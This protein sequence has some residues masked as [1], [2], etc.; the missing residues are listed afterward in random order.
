MPDD[1][2]CPQCGTPLQP[3]ALA[4]LCPACLLRQGAA[5]DTITGAGRAFVPPSIS[6]LSAKFPQLEILSLIG[7]GGM[8]AVYKARQRGL[9]R[10]VA[11]KILPPAI[12]EDPAFAGR[13]ARE[14]KALAKLNHPGIVTIHDFGCADGL[15]FFLMEFVDGVNLR[16]LLNAG[17]V[18]PREALAI[19]PQ[20]C[21]ALQFAHDQ[22]IVHRDIK[23]ENILLDRLGRVKVA[24]FGLAKLIGNEADSLPETGG[25]STHSP[26]LTEAGKIMGTPSYMAPEQTEH[27]DEVDHRADIYALGVV[28][29]QMLTGELPGKCVEAPSKKVRIDVRLDEVVL[30]ALEKNPDLRYAQASVFKTQVETIAATPG[31]AAAHAAGIAAKATYTSY[32]GFWR[33]ALALFIDCT[34]V[35]IVVFPFLMAMD[36]IAPGSAVVSVPFHLFTTEHVIDSKQ[37]GSKNADGSTTAVDNRIVEVTVLN[38]WKY[39]YRD[40]ISHNAGDETKSRQLID[41]S[42]RQNIGATS[43]DDLEPWFLLIY[44]ILMESSIYQASIGKMMTG[45]RVVDSNG[46]RLSLVRATGRNI[47]KIVSCLTLMIGFM[48]AGWTKRKQALHDI[49]AGC[50]VTT[51]QKPETASAWRPGIERGMNSTPPEHNVTPPSRTEQTVGVVFAWAG[52]ILQLGL[53]YGVIWSG[54]GMMRT[55]ALIGASGIID[56]KTLAGAIGSVLEASCIGLVTGILGLVLLS[57]ALMAMRYRAPWFYW[58]LVINSWLLIFAFPIGTGFAIFF[59]IYCSKHRAEFFILPHKTSDLG[60]GSTPLSRLGLG[61]LLL[62]VLGTP[63]LLMFFSREPAADYIAVFALLTILLALI[64]GIISRTSRLGR[65]VIWGCIA[66]IIG[67]GVLLGFSLHQRKI[68]SKRMQE[69][70]L[71]H[72][73][74]QETEMLQAR[75]KFGPVT[76][77]VVEMNNFGGYN[78]ATGEFF[79]ETSH[80]SMGNLW[81]DQE[82]QDHFGV[83]LVGGATNGT[84]IFLGGAAREVDESAWDKPPFEVVRDYIF[85]EA[86]TGEKTTG[87]K[88]PNAMLDSSELLTPAPGRFEPLSLDRWNK[89]KTYLFRTRQG[90]IGLLQ[91]LEIIQNPPGMKIVVEQG[92]ERKLLE[93]VAGT[94]GMKFR[95]KLVQDL[96][97]KKTAPGPV[98]PLIRDTSDTSPTLRC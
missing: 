90:S 53:L 23:P 6:E 46:H 9:D 88:S 30:R 70:M 43:T 77:R 26:D 2:K 3:G 65:G 67:L 13:F 33:R 96:A 64:F 15:F 31:D 14:A 71:E 63:L 78:L 59:L 85:H 54:V 24:D 58:F 22:G 91:T 83:D 86:A 80:P 89:H 12:G 17:R 32:A 21:D 45:I 38:K 68:A 76:E 35:S 95:Y 36:W 97:D 81:Y 34:L 28:F 27:P 62:G 72:Q 61:L 44:W 82:W 73:A 50:Y 39:C 4:G 7:K 18:S 74:K 16:Q 10:I 79:E 41:P 55:F 29:Y 20:I 42:S 75:F 66:V 49:M 84:I 98:K 48:M 25:E 93:P 1:P 60:P 51:L 37:A 69:V 57:I 40:E 8:G 11:L 87:S 47:S 92:K 94:T 52:A 56:A 5:A 19:V